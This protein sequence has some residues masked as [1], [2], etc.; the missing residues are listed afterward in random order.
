[1][2]ERKLV[3]KSITGDRSDRWNEHGAGMEGRVIETRLNPLPPQ[4]NC[5]KPQ[6]DL[7]WNIVENILNQGEETLLKKRYV[8]IGGIGIIILIAGA[9]FLSDSLKIGPFGGSAHISEEQA[10]SITGEKTDGKKSLTAMEALR[11]GYEAAKKLTEEEPL[12]IYL[13]STDNSSD[14]QERNDGADG[15]R[16]AWNLTFGSAKRN[17]AIS[18][19]INNGNVNIGQVAKDDNNSLQKGRYAISDIQIDSSEAVQRAIEV[20]G[21]RPGNPEIKDDWIKGYHFVISGFQTDPKNPT[22]TRLLLRVTGISPNSPNSENQSLRMNVY[23]D[24]KTGE[25]LNASEQTG[26]DKDGRSMW[27]D[28]EL[29]H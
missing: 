12:L 24:G 5:G 13:T 16:N 9:V 10:A 4:Y 11:L 29:K 20:L 6:F 14:P 26:Y 21:M 15:K 27:R 18:M 22:E 28:I 7:W 19:N 25:M 23:F 8:N 3:F 1:M 17:I 2:P